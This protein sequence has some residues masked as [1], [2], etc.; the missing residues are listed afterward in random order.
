MLETIPMSVN[1]TANWCAVSEVPILGQ[2]EIHVWR[3]NLVQDVEMED[4]LK[5]CLSAEESERSARFHFV[6][7]QRRFVV[8]RAVLRHLLA[9]YMNVNPKIVRLLPAPHGKPVVHGQDGSTGLRFSCS[10]SANL[11]LVAIARGRELGVDLERH[12]P[13]ADAEELT[14]AFFSPFEIAELAGMSQALKKKSF[15]DCWTRKEA[16]VKAIG[17]GLSFPLNRFAVSLAPDRPAAL[18]SV[19]G[20]PNAVDRWTMLSLNVDAD[21]SA[22]LVFEGKSAGLQCFEW[23]SR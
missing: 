9:G 17:M 5:G 18:L 16:F 10:H 19:E 13:L 1:Q 3:I 8:R 23:S 7:D 2:S 11:G 12:R 15:F 4:W 21:Y 6:Q 22:A 20:Y 14:N